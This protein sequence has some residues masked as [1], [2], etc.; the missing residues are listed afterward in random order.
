MFFNFKKSIPEISKNQIRHKYDKKYDLW[1]YSIVDVIALAVNT[2]DARNYWKVLKNRLNK[3]EKKE[4]VT[5]CNQLKLP[6]KDGKSYLTD[7]F[8]SEDILEFIDIIAPKE[9]SKFQ[10]FFEEVEGKKH[11]LTLSNE[12]HNFEE[13]EEVAE[14]MIDSWQNEKYFFVEFMI[15]GLSVLDLKICFSDN[16]LYITGKR[17]NQNLNQDYFKQELFWGSFSKDLKLPFKINLDKFDA[18]EYKG[19]I[20]LKFKKE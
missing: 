2:K 3:Q 17:G 8:A 11:I 13:N 19:M 6:S 7:T 20:T 12:T 10:N 16:T 4:L 18:T 14:L 9:H 5:K 15:A 1:Y